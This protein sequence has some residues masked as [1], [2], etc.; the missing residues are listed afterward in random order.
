MLRQS[1]LEF[2]THSSLDLGEL[3]P[4]GVRNTLGRQQRLRV[5]SRGKSTPRAATL[6]PN[7]FASALYCFGEVIEHHREVDEES[8]RR[9]DAPITLLNNPTI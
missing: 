9:H 7:P 4:A 5:L 6:W 1:L 2:G 3:D 8:G